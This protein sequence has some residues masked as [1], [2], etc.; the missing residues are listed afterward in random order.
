MESLSEATRQAIVLLLSGNTELWTIIGIS[1]RVSMTAILI[2]T[3]PALLTAFALSHWRF[4][5]RRLLL[6]LF[7]TFLSKEQLLILA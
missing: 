4:P 7:S 2:A 3:V 6:T 1:F 5:G